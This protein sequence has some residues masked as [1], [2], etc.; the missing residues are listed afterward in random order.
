MIGKL[1]RRMQTA[2]TLSALT[3]SLCLLID[4]MMVGRFLG[5]GALEA[6]SLA[7]PVLLIVAGFSSLMAAGVQVACSKS[8]GRGAREE[9]D[10]CC[11]TNDSTKDSSSGP[12]LKLRQNC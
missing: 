7:S 8:L 5:V 12:A 1:V 11:S 2:Q 6:N 9:T 4:N 10:S 3:V